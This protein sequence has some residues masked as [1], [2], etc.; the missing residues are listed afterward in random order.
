MTPHWGKYFS[1]LLLP[2]TPLALSRPFKGLFELTSKALN[3][4]CALLP[5][6]RESRILSGQARKPSKSPGH[7]CQEQLT[8]TLI[9]L[10]LK[11]HLF[12]LVQKFGKPWPSLAPSLTPPK[13]WS[14]H[15]Y[16]SDP[17]HAVSSLDLDKSWVSPV[18]A[19]WVF[20]QPVVVPLIR[21]AIAHHKDSVVLSIAPEQ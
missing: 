10:L 2:T 17:T 20:D 14:Y 4:P 21:S 1:L 5:E 3:P 11:T 16:V 7:C 8:Q 12:W 13:Y 15:P 19:P 18:I 9:V 6:N